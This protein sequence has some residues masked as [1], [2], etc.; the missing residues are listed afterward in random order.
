MQLLNNNGG[1]AG[2][3]KGG[4]NTVN[5]GGVFGEALMSELNPKYH[6]L[7]K[8]GKVFTLAS[9]ALATI[10]AFTGA[11]AGTPIAGIYNPST[12]GVDLV[13]LQTKVAIGTTGTTAGAMRFGYWAANQGAVS[14]SGTQT[15]PRQK[16]SLGNG[17]SATYCTVNAAN[18]GAVASTFLEP[19]FSLG[20]VT[21][22]AGVNVASLIETFDGEII[23]PPGGYLAWGSYV[24]MA[25][26]ALDFSLTWAEVTAVQ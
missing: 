1:F 14:P 24:A 16:Y 15:V 25:V 8:T 12:S 5:P 26:A 21:T 23:I 3:A 22:T 7:V 13:L 4:P 18:T 6:A 19:S 2:L 11:A 17:G 20:N 9:A 10:T